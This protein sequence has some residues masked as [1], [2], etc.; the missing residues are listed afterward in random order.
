LDALVVV[1]KSCK[2]ETCIQ[3]WKVLH[4]EGDVK[5][6]VDSLKPGFDVFYHEQPKVSFS[7]CELGYIKESEGP[8]EPKSYSSDKGS[9]QD[10]EDIQKGLGSKESFRYQGQLGWWT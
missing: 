3:P 4:P 2:G 9:N 5:S 7:K 8:L 10:S 1:L 6:L